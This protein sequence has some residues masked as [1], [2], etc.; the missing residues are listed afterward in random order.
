MQLTYCQDKCIA[1]MRPNLS[2]SAILKV[3][4]APNDSLFW[5]YGCGGNIN[6][7]RMFTG[8]PLIL[9]IREL[10]P[11]IEPGPSFPSQFSR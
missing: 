10:R 7:Y 5:S 2:E 11:T 1:D 6:S 4:S 3:P 8:I 9:A